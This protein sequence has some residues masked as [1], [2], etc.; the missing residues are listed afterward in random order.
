MLK[1]VYLICNMSDAWVLTILIDVDF[2]PK[3]K[4]LNLT[5]FS[6]MIDLNIHMML[7]ASELGT[8]KK[9]RF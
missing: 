1:H 4:M 3:F 7:Y 9:T 2:P 8:Y 5:N 6:W